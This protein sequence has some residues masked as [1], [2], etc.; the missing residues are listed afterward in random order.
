M[1]CIEAWSGALSS[2][3]DV[4]IKIQ[5]KIVGGTFSASYNAHTPQYL[6]TEHHDTLYVYSCLMRPS[7]Y[8]LKSWIRCLY[9][10]KLF[11]IRELDISHVVIIISNRL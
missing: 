2:Y 10:I 9:K 3:K 7:I 4:L 8:I 6:K 11:I 1:Y 5:K